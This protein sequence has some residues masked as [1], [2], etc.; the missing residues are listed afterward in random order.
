MMQPESEILQ[1]S[2]GAVVYQNYENGYSVVRLQCDDGQTATVVGTIP[3]PAVGERL[4]VT[5]RWSSQASY[6]RQ[7]EAEFRERL[8]PRTESEILRYLSSR[9]LKGVGPVTASRIVS[10]SVPAPCRC[11][12]RNPPAW[13]RSRGSPRPRPSVSAKPI[14]FRWACGS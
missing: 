11:W 7:V 4:M 10:D 12:S 6:G 14:G 9:V 13:R 8:L 5:G 3:L 2:I 1:G